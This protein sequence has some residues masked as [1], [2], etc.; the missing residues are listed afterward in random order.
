MADHPLRPATRL[1]LGGPLPRQLAD[2]PRTPPGVIACRSR[3]HLLPRTANCLWSY[4]VLVRLSTGYPRLQGR[5]PTCY[6][7]VRRF[8]IRIATKF[9]H[10]LHVSGTPPAF[11]LSQDQT[12]QKS[13]I[14][15][16]FHYRPLT[17]CRGRWPTDRPLNSK[18]TWTGRLYQT[19]AAQ[20]KA[21][22]TIQFSKTRPFRGT[23]NLIA[24]C[25]RSQSTRA[26]SERILEWI[27]RECHRRDRSARLDSADR[28]NIR[29]SGQLQRSHS[30]TTSQHLLFKSIVTQRG[31]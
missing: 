21:C 9:S 29:P 11:V 14:S 6:S 10:D 2:R 17:P 23:P 19:P 7:P 25:F 28:R 1:C 31:V 16:K 4:L 3:G 24:C 5:L 27:G 8:T 13:L 26:D 18:V 22:T 12:L 15:S 30:A 20:F